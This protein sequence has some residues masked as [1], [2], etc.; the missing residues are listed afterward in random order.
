M[1]AW[2]VH[3]HTNITWVAADA[4]APEENE[5]TGMAA[6]T[7]GGTAGAIACSTMAKSACWSWR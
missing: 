1:T 6:A 7:I 5:K 3:L 2:A 4:V